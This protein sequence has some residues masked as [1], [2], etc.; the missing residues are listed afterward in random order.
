MRIYLAGPMRNYPRNN[1]PAFDVVAKAMRWMVAL[2]PLL[3]KR[4]QR[5]I[6]RALARSAEARARPIGQRGVK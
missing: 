1:F 5:Q 6:V 4:R 3:G 2:K